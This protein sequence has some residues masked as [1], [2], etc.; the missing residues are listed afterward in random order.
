[1]KKQLIGYY[2]PEK[3]EFDKLWDDSL[4]ILDTNVL[5]NL[6]RYSKK[7]SDDFLDTLKKISDRL[8]IPYEVALEYHDNRINVISQQKIVYQEI[9]DFLEAHESKASSKILEY[10]RHPLIEAKKIQE[11]LQQTY[12]EI[13]NDLRETEKEH[14]D[15]T[16]NDP[17]LDE[18]TAIFT[19]K[20][21]LKYPPEK[22]QEIFKEG[23]NRYQSKI[24]PGYEDKTKKS[25]HEL[26]GDLI[27]WYQII[28]Q[29]KSI[30]KPIIFVT[31]DKKEDWWRKLKGKTLGPKPEL[32]A[33]IQE[34]A[35][36]SFYMYNSDK[37]LLYAKEYLQQKVNQDTLV[38]IRDNR[39]VESITEAKRDTEVRIESNRDSF[40][41]GKSV[42][43]S[44]HSY[45]NDVFVRLIVFGPGKYS[46][47]VEIATPSISAS[48]RWNYSWCPELDTNP[49]LY[50][51]FVY[52]AQKHV[53][54]EVTVRAEKGAITIFAAGDQTCYIGERIKL[55]GTSTASKEVYLTILG[56][57]TLPDSRK[58]DDFSVFSKNEDNTSF[59]HLDVRA[60][61]SWSYIWD[62]AIV[63][64]FLKS[65]FYTIYAIE[66]PFTP[67][68]LREKAF[69][70]V[71]ILIK[72]PFV[73]GTVSQAAFA[74]G[75]PIFITGTAEG[76]PHQKLQIW[77]FNDSFVHHDVIRTNADASYVYYLSPTITKNL[78]EGHFF[79]I[80]QHP[81][82]NNE[83]D[84]YPDN[85]KKMVLTNFPNKATQLFSF[86]GPGSLRGA[87]AAEETLKA[88]NNPNIDDTYT[89]L[90]FLIDNPVIRFG[91]IENKHVGDK[92]TITATTNLAVDN[93]I[94]IE[95]YSSSFDP[96]QKKY[97]R[98]F[99]GASGVVKVLKGNS[100]MNVIA[101]DLDTS[102]FEPDEY[103]VKASAML[104]DVNVEVKFNII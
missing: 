31:D 4:I 85:I 56:P 59:I 17:I 64:T 96:N 6:Y 12:L 42:D 26:Y 30:K 19:E 76:V 37:F 24:P 23:Q 97:S 51:I 95:I 32:V 92:I 36:V 100:G 75:D 29:A 86:D 81:M 79:V 78:Q 99:S 62:T 34:K 8:W 60:D 48:H 103:I 94:M 89:K 1:M 93:E 98:A 27:L 9:F 73:S 90:V 41:I 74:K 18:I 58:L 44:G 11:R 54:D 15:L 52:D 21:G 49:G 28:D 43:L 7:T 14:P 72:K 65:G 40:I 10:S 87:N 47:G 101:F 80:I 38:E 61:Y 84:V 55:A 25:D 50:T 16:L 3:A 67:N 20:V 63:G 83:F 102:T 82:M 39:L 22:L 5:L 88:I 70:T 53:S 2:L 35:N 71:S 46:E 45:S 13:K 104:V 57:D 77:I 68:N 91:S 69:G 66:G 33:E